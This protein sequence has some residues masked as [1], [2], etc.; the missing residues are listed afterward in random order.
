MGQLESSDT[1]EFSIVKTDESFSPNGTMWQDRVEKK[2]WISSE[3]YRK[4]TV[5]A[6]C[7]QTYN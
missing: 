4:S 1:D 6:V 2:C 7:G 5:A 3:S